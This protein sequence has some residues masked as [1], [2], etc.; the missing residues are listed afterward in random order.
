MASRIADRSLAG[1]PTLHMLCGKVAAGKSTLAAR[2]AAAPFTVLISEDAWTSRLYPEELKT[3]A[4]YAKYARR[5][6]EAMGPH[7]ATL[8]EAGLSVVL[9]FP[10]NTVANRQW[11]RGIFEAAG[12]QHRLHLLDLP[13]AACKQRLHRRNA[14]GAHDFTVSDAEFDLITSYFVRPTAAEGFDTIVY[15]E[16]ELGA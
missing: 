8:L 13:D 16:A 11:M 3:V 15:A 14:G 6:R 7:V 2:L 5:L 12:A 4:D 10:A 9:D 1:V